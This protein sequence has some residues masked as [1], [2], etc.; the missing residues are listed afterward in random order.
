MKR[1]T[2]LAL[3]AA[4]LIS[5]GGACAHSQDFAREFLFKVPFDFVVGEQK[6]PMGTYR[7]SRENSNI[8]L[9]QARGGG[10]ALVLA[11]A[12]SPDN[13]QPT[14]GK[15][16]FNRYGNKYFLHEV[17]CRYPTMN[18]EIKASRLEKQAQIQNS[19]LPGNTRT[20]AVLEMPEHR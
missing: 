17:L 10:S 5:I 14:G 15:L 2:P 19:S 6:L 20:V 8:L 11:S 3:F 18:A 12:P 4:A 7:V 9:I 13:G 16:V 1:S